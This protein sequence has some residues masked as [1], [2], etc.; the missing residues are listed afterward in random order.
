MTIIVNKQFDSD[1]DE[2]TNRQKFLTR[3][4]KAIKEHQ[5][6]QLEKVATRIETLLEVAEKQQKALDESVKKL[7]EKLRE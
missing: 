1:K 3:N 4:K 2:A 7:G 5:H 6:V